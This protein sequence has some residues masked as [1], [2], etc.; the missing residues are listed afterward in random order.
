MAVASFRTVIL[1]NIQLKGQEAKKEAGRAVY[2]F[3]LPG[4]AAWKVGVFL[5]PLPFMFFH[6]DSFK[7]IKPDLKHGNHSKYGNL[8]LTALQ[9]N[10]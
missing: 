2:T 3:P 5:P 1:T 6:Q 7:G 10:P 8:C 4:K 9:C